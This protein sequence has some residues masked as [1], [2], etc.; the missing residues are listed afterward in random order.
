MADA[1]QLERVKV[2]QRGHDIEITGYPRNRKGIAADE[3]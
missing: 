1:L 2:T 3:G